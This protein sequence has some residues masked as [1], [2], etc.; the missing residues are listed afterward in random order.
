MK[1]LNTYLSLFLIFCFFSCSTSKNTIEKEEHQFPAVTIV[2]TVGSIDVMVDPNVELMNVIQRLVG[3]PPYVSAKDVPYLAKVDEYF[4][5]YKSST[6]VK[7]LLL[8]G[9]G[10]FR[11]SEFGM[12]LNSDDSDFIMKPDNKKF[13][14]S[15]GPA[16]KIPYYSFSS[17]REAVRE[18]RIESKFDQFFLSNTTDYEEQ[19]EK[20]VQL[21]KTYN[22]DSWLKDFYGTKQKENSCLYVTKVTG[23]Y[24][25]SFVNPKGKNIPHAVVRDQPSAAN[26]LFLISHE[27]SHPMTRQIVDELYKDTTIRSIFDKLYSKNAILYN[28]NGYGNGYY[29]LN[30]TI[31]QG[32]A[33]KFN[34]KIFPENIMQ[35][36]YSWEAESMKMVYVPAITKFLD[37]YQ[38][39][40]NTYKTLKA[41]VPE[42]KKFLV[43]L[44]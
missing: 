11:P 15:D 9:L 41:F 31:N 34:E 28:S 38:N 39:N 35:W 3:L 42:L 33:N 24:G 27:F 19:I 17:V 20:H 6:A 30:E 18:F 4:E 36:F 13:V 29:V 1:K 21:L 7:L 22:F 8:N 26:A 43:T 12:Y 32:C 2:K 16:Q 40:R 10:N 25:I 37:N 14:V 44:E 23:N 5:P